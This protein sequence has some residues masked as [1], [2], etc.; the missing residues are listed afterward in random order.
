MTQ[1]L[2]H[3]ERKTSQIPA[4]RELDPIRGRGHAVPER[5]HARRGARS[6]RRFAGL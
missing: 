2:A 6:P 4:V 1:N 5:F 3:G